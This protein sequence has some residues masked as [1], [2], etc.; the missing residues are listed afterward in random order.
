V[1][2]LLIT[3]PPAL[4]EGA[5][6]P[7][8]PKAFLAAL[9]AGMALTIGACQ[10]SIDCEATCNTLY[11][12]GECALESAGWQQNELLDHCNSECN[13]AL[14][15]VG[16]PRKDYKPEEY[17]PSNNDEVTFINDS[18]VAL[19]MDCV[20]ETACDLLDDGYCAPVW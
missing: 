20:D 8:G 19:W 3:L 15:T 13:T 11:Q 2:A 9:F 6:R 1:R 10:P 14:K 4:M 7:T 17:T 12:S 5:M 16:D 18:E